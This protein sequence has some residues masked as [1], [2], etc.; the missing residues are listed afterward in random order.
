MSDNKAEEKTTEQKP[1]RRRIVWIV[2]ILV[3]LGLALPISN[4][5]I[6]RTYLEVDSDDEQFQQVS[7][8]LQK[9]CADCHTP[10]LLQRPIY[11]SFPIA[12]SIIAKDVELA[13]MHF[14]L[15]V[16]Q[17]RG[18]EP[19]NAVALAKIE[20]VV[21]H[22]SMPPMRY[23]ALHWDT[24]IGAAE[25]KLLEDWLESTPGG[26]GP[27]PIP[28]VNPFNPDSAK[29]A[30]GE[31]LY[32]DVRLSGDDTVSC[33]TCHGLDTGGVDG[34]VTSTGIGGQKGPINAPTV[35]NAAFNFAQFW[36][37]RA[38][39]LKEQAGGPVLNPLEMGAQWEPVIEKLK[40]DE[41]YVAAFDATYDGVIS[42]DTVTDAIAEFEKTL[43]TPNSRFDQYL[44]GDEGALTDEEQQG[45]K[46]FLSHECAICHTGVNLGGL[47]YE[48][49]GLA[50]DY[51]KMRGGEMT[52]A[53]LG[54]FNVTMEETDRSKF[55]TPTLRNIALTGPYFH[56]GSA[57]TL[58]EAVRTMTLVQS[59]HELTDE[60][61][62][63]IA[64]F[65]NTL[66]G[67]YQGK[68]LGS[69]GP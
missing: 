13:Q 11:F 65:L 64:K 50:R 67:E 8:L 27:Q 58:E 59:G 68:P 18:E 26:L 39:D 37:G 4:L 31:K 69:D 9:N 30:L 66:T 3:L 2:A 44:R 42:S 29:V 55:K 24:G 61:A 46:L 53:D 20:E 1:R 32:H 17:L 33:A 41:A 51:F 7:R 22:G 14:V 28:L 47:T 15:T 63:Q 36:D 57:K 62:T 48:K 43:L 35:Y 38:A 6:G 10:D 21:E 49:I 45:Y 16:D 34:G 12:S 52:D 60:E 23:I 5:L 19:L 40:A 56:D 54:R 25:E